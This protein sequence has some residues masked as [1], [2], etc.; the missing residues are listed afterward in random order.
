MV[1]LFQSRK[2]GREESTWHNMQMRKGGFG[3]I[4]GERG[5]GLPFPF[6]FL[7]FCAALLCKGIGRSFFWQLPC[8]HSWH[9]SESNF[10]FSI[11]MPRILLVGK[12]S[13]FV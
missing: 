8:S 10:S 9:R 13:P 1:P 7:D 5:I 11:L 12:E 2:K 6:L 4:R 3:I